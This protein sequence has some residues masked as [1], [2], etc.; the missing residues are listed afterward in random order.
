MQFAHP[1]LDPREQM[2]IRAVWAGKASRIPWQAGETL[3]VEVEAGVNSLPVAGQM[4]LSAAI[5][6]TKAY[7]PRDIKPFKLQRL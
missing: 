4:N 5:T 1:S 7:R 3:G 2:R 6:E